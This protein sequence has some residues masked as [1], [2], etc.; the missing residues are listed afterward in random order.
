V[1]GR[2]I[3]KRKA[4]DL[5]SLLISWPVVRYLACP[6]A[7]KPIGL[8]TYLSWFRPLSHALRVV[9]HQPSPVRIHI[10]YEEVAG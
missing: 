2:P 5:F 7:V 9:L 10:G 8:S 4:N 6:P 1:L 3:R